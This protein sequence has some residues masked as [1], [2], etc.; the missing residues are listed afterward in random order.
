M[1]VDFYLVKTFEASMYIQTWHTISSNVEVVLK[2]RGKQKMLGHEI[3]IFI[4]V[5]SEKD[6]T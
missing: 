6:V 2:K 5:F 1:I 4:G 3:F